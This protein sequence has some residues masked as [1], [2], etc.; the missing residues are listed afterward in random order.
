MYV[1]RKWLTILCG[2]ERNNLRGGQW[3]REM[4]R[5]CILEILLSALFCDG[6]DCL[7]HCV[8]NPDKRMS[9]IYM[10]SIFVFILN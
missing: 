1:L 8:V 2:T 6:F 9:M 5:L 10:K 3:G 4:K 7:F